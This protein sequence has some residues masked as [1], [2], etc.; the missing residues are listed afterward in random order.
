MEIQGAQKSQNHLEE[1]N[2]RTHSDF[3]TYYKGG[4]YKK[5]I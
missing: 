3:K 5:Y 4:T 2:W 1:E